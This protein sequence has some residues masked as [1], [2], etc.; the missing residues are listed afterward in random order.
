MFKD[1]RRNPEMSNSPQQLNS[2]GGDRRPAKR[3]EKLYERFMDA[4]IR[5]W[6]TQYRLIIED[7][8]QAGRQALT[9]AL[10]SRRDSLGGFPRFYSLFIIFSS[11]LRLARTLILA[12]LMRLCYFSPY[13]WQLDHRQPRRRLFDSCK[14]IP[15]IAPFVATRR[16]TKPIHLDSL[17][18][19]SSS[20]NRHRD[21]WE[22]GRDVI[23]DWVL[24]SES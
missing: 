22:N 24:M 9:Y 17:E 5:S 8:V 11:L 23:R 7:E 18:V 4:I 1:W 10:N 3:S 19:V 21:S 14:P 13:P 16:A 6:V 15:G 2:N 12:S 20:A